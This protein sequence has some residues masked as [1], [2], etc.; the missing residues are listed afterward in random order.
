[1]GWTQYSLLAI[2]SLI[3]VKTY[4]ESVTV[5]PRFRDEEI[6]YERLHS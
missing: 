1:M 5:A 4:E 6:D 3:L 2:G